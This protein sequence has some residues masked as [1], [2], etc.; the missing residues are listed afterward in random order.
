MAY[1]NDG[2][3]CIDNSMAERSIR[4]LTIERKNK[5][6]FGSHKGVETSTVYHTFIATCKMNALT[7]RQFLKN[8]FTAYMDG[9]TDFENMTPVILS[10]TY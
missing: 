4:P 1:R 9:R 10:K 3:Y 8:Y 7:F 6:N 5:M 2:Q